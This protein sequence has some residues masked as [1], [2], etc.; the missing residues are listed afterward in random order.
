MRHHYQMLM[1]FS[2]FQRRMARRYEEVYDCLR[3]HRYEEA[4]MLL[5][6]ITR[7][8]AK[9]ALSLRGVLVKD[10]QIKESKK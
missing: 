1:A 8:H 9:A 3:A 2:K 7:S 6:D 4:E 5:S 10:G